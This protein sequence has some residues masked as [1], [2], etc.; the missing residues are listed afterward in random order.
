MIAGDKGRCTDAV[1]RDVAAPAA[2]HGS[3]YSLVMEKVLKE[4][5]GSSNRLRRKV[6]ESCFEHSRDCEPASCVLD[7]GKGHLDGIVAPLQ[8]PWLVNLKPANIR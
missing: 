1:R 8:K 2:E 7:V 5:K 6:N 4:D 3:V